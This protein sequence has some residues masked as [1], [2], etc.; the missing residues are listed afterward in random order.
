LVDDASF[1][2]R[3]VSVRPRLV[4]L[5]TSLVGADDA[6]DVVHDTYLVARRQISQLRDPSALETWLA[7]IAVNLCY[8]QHRRRRRVVVAEIAETGTAPTR[9][10]ALREL[11]ER[12]PARE[13]TIVVLHYGHGYRLEEIAE[14]LSLTYT[15]V[16][17]IIART[18][19]RL[20]RQWS[21]GG[22]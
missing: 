22:Q 20:F 10:L 4:G 8:S 5:C 6:Q 2:T 17:S 12:L 7:R 15:N 21:E 9:D 14:M 13:R 19:K 3:F 16:R 18:R 11:I 1:E